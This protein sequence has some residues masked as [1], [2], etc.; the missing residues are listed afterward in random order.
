MNFAQTMQNMGCQR[1]IFTDI[2]RDGTLS[3][4][5]AAALRAVSEAV[6]IPVIASGGVHKATDLRILR[7]IPNI[8]GA[9]VGK[10]L[11][12]GT[13]T[14]AK[15]IEINNEIETTDKTENRG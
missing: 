14:L 3:G 7:N 5:N 1:I 15:L 10:A 8:E 12:E 6:E 13:T 4:P 9:I 2:A 11:Y